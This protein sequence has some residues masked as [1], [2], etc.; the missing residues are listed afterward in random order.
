M[1]MTETNGLYLFPPGE[2]FSEHPV[3]R[4]LKSV[5]LGDVR[6]PYGFFVKQDDGGKYVV[7][8]T[9]EERASI[10]FNAFPDMTPEELRWQGC[11]QVSGNRCQG[12]CPGGHGVLCFAT[13]EP[14]SNYHG[15]VCHPG[16]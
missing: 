14:T 8:A 15:C 2:D 16:E 12:S 6:F 1:S 9:P 7:P 5:S 4:A 11:H 3:F 10:L 13:Y